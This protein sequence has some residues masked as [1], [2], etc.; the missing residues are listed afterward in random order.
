MSDKLEEIINQV[1]KGLQHKG[2]LSLAAEKNIRTNSPQPKNFAQAINLPNKLSIIAEIKRKS[3]SAGDLKTG[4]IPSVL[5]K[6]YAEAGA[7]ALSI[8]TNGSHFGGKIEDL[9]E[10]YK[11]VNIPLLCKDFVISRRQIFEAKKHGASAILLIVAALSDAELKSLGNLAKELGMSALVEVHDKK[12]LDRA[13]KLETKLLGINNRNL[14]DLTTKL[15][16]TLELAPRVPK[17]VVLVAESGY[18]MPDDI[19]KLK[20]TGVNA[21]LIGESL[22]R[23]E[24]PGKALKTLVEAGKG[25]V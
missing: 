24:N 6:E 25:N 20:G 12:E 1:K 18:K 7:S 10:V 4:L 21:V 16:T 11:V 22:L 3:P 23:N 17:D 19:K 13:L 5:A 8:L 15:S 9:L 14:K 2:Q